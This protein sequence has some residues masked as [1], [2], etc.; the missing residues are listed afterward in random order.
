M[1]VLCLGTA[2]A[3]QAGPAT[4][5]P[6]AAPSPQQTTASFDDWVVRCETRAGPPQRKICEMVQF[7]Q[8]KGQQGVLSEVAIGRPVKN[9]PIKIVIQV[10]IGI[11]LPTGIKLVAGAGDPGVAATFKRCIPQSCFAD[12]EIKDDTI[13]R[14]RAGGNGGKLEFKDG[15]QKDVS[16]PVSFKGFGAA[17]DALLK[18]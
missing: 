3:G 6:A 10:P 18:E 17:Y 2:L 16:L 9:Q 4:A 8:T 7:T 1:L 14:L 5:Q 13:R 15:N 12:A 11:W